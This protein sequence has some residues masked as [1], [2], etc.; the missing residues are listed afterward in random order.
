MAVF[1]VV[2]AFVAFLLAGLLVDGG[3]AINARLKAADVA[4]Q[5]ARAGADQID[6]DTLRATGQA[7]LVRDSAAVC[8][9]AR[10]IVNAQA[11]DGV[12][13]ESCTPSRTQVTIEVTAHWDTIFLSAI[14]INGT[15]MEGSATAAPDAGGP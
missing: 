1:T 11:A 9:A 3:A 13:W 10:E 6:T 2:F 8:A 4:E 7:L 12:R 5:A 14:G 15:T